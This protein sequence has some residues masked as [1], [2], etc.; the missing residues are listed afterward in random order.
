VVRSRGFAFTTDLAAAWDYCRDELP[1]SA[2]V[3]CAWLPPNTATWS[4]IGGRRAYLDYIPVSAILDPLLLPQGS[5]K[6][7]ATLIQQVY[8]SAHPADVARLVRGTPVTHLIE[9]GHLSMRTHPAGLL[10]LVWQ[11][12]HGAA[13]IWEIIRE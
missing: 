5:V 10:R 12:P 6:N 9:L 1:P 13:R 7:R 8:L 2:V 3:M 11:S 4:G